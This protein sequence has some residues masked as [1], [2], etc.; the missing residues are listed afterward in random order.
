VGLP[1]KLGV[2]LAI[3]FLGCWICH[4]DLARDQPD[5][6]QVTD[7]Y[8]WISVG[9]FVGGIFGNLVAPRLFDSVAEYPLS[10]ALVAILLS[11]WRALGRGAWIRFALTAA[12]FVGWT[13]VARG[14]PPRHWDDVF[15]GLLLLGA[16]L[17][18]LPGQFAAACVCAALINSFG[19]LSGVK[20]LEARRSFF[21]VSRVRELAGRR[22]LVH[23]TTRHGVQKVDPF[24]PQPVLYY[25]PVSP[26]SRVVNLQ[27]EDARMAVV[28]LGCGALAY[29]TKPGQVMRYFEIDPIIEPLARRWF[30]FLKDGKAT[31]DVTLGD[32]RLTLRALED[33]S[34]DLVFVDAFSSDSIPV[35]LIT[36]EAMQLY[37]DKLKPDG[38]VVMHL[39]NRYLDL[40]RVPRAI[41]RQ[42]G[43]SLVHVEYRPDPDYPLAIIQVAALARSEAPLQKLVDRGWK[44]PPPGPEV[45]WTDDRSNLLSVLSADMN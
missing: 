28:G 37:L 24:D 41:A 34:Q 36:V 42:L 16:A 14:A 20:T 35:H 30:T 9:G 32:A 17:F 22:S 8:L 45:L 39:S 44:Q 11:D 25:T 2:P 19:V 23:G 38:I 6:E 18:K 4:T 43:L 31:I 27:K 7:Y 33:H 13:L 21:G 10:L 26:L 12:V 40:L 15:L 3:L 1:L 5:P 29:Y